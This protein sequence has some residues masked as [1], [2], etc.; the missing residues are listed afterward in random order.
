MNINVGS[1]NTAKQYSV[2]ADW[3]GDNLGSNNSAIAGPL[4]TS[5][6]VSYAS[7]IYADMF[8]N[9]RGGNAARIPHCTGCHV[10]G[11][12]SGGFSLDGGTSLAIY[13]ELKGVNDGD[14]RISDVA[15]DYIVDCVNDGCNNGGGG[16]SARSSTYTFNASEITILDK[17]ITQGALNN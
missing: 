14:S 9:A 2:Y 15:P 8:V 5:T 17:W 11:A 6:L 10:G 12:P 3:R 1:S 16:M 4:L 7:D 13:N